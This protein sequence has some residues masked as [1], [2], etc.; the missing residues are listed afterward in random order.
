MHLSSR[1]T[2]VMFEHLL[3]LLYHDPFSCSPLF[4]SAVYRGN[5]EFIDS[6]TEPT[7]KRRT[8]VQRISVKPEHSLYSIVLLFKSN[9]IRPYLV[10][11][12]Q[13]IYPIQSLLTNVYADILS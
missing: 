1:S 10:H 3:P 9:F 11:R 5:D 6:I 13:S 7:Y 8:G 4:F 2:S 12:K